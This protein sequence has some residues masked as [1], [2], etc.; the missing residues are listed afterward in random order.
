[1]SKKLNLQG[2]KKNEETKCMNMCLLFNRFIEQ[3]FCIV[4]IDCISFVHHLTIQ[5]NY[6]SLYYF[7]FL[8]IYT[9]LRLKLKSNLFLSLYFCLK[10]E[11]FEQ[12]A[13]SKMF[14]YSLIV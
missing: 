4:I 7:G 1:M 14:A 13:H 8:F 5:I 10:N 3:S 6:L 9:S 11:K 2:F 12:L